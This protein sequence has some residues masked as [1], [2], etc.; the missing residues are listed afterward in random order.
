MGGNALKNTFTRRYEK[1]EYFVLVE[2]VLLALKNLFPNIRTEVIKAYGG[3]ESFGDM[4]VLI[5]LDH[6]PNN[7]TKYVIDYFKPNE[8]FKN[9]DV[10]SFDYK[11]FQIDLIG[12]K[13]ESFDFS[14][15]Y[16]SYNDLG[17]LMGR[18]AHKMGLKFGHQGLLYV[19]R[20]EDKVIKEIVLSTSAE[21]VLAFLGYDY[22]RHQ[23]GFDALEDVFHFAVSTP[24]FNPDIYLLDNLNHKSRVRDAK[25]K[26]Y[27]EFLLWL[28]SDAYLRKE[29]VPYPYNQDKQFYKP[30]ILNFFSNAIPFVEQALADHQQLLAFRQRFNGN[31][32]KDLTGLDGKELG[33][34]LQRM[35]KE[36]GGET[37]F[38]AKILSLSDLQI[39]ELILTTFYDS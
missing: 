6:L 8:N 30:F 34:F 2:E 15:T 12:T 20:E 9:G 10:F 18:I 32:V 5:E 27:N 31:L 33:G 7:W 36:A 19:L 13:S 29:I 23:Q 35:M 1:V 3:K 24:Y 26:T 14:A 38:R 4:D 25:R 21:E 39:R 37:E 28:Q 16:F 17:N 22:A 11:E